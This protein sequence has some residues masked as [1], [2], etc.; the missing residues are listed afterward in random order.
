LTVVDGL[1]R[2]DCRSEDVIRGQ[3]RVPELPAG[4]LDPHAKPQFLLAVEQRYLAHL[5]QVDADWIVDRASVADAHQLMAVEQVIGFA[6]LVPVQRHW[7]RCPRSLLC[8]GRTP[9]RC[10]ACL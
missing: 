9:N 8:A 2:D 4:L 1:D 6:I 5:H 10:T 3:H 7:R